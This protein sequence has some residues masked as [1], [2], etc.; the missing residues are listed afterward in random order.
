M[1]NNDKAEKTLRFWKASLAWK[2]IGEWS[3]GWTQGDFIS[4]LRDLCLDS[5][6]LGHKADNLLDD[7]IK[8]VERQEVFEGN[9]LPLQKKT[10]ISGQ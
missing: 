7:M 2:N 10:I 3:K 4:E 5:G 1:L 6:V 8:G 9:V